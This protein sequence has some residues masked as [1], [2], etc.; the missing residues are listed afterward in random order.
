MFP[1]NLSSPIVNIYFLLF[2]VSLQFFGR[3]LVVDNL[4]VFLVTLVAI[5]LFPF[6]QISLAA[7][8]G[9]M[10]WVCLQVFFW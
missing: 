1:A 6:S 9:L 8:R 3:L 7:M 10:S 5:K 4:S 2:F